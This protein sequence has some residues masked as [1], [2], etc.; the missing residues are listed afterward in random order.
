MNFLEAFGELDKLNEEVLTEKQWVAINPKG[1]NT[2]YR[3]L[4][5]G[6]QD[7]GIGPIQKADIRDM[8]GNHNGTYKQSLNKKVLAALKSELENVS[9]TTGNNDYTDLDNC[10]IVPEKAIPGDKEVQTLTL[11]DRSLRQQA[12]KDLKRDLKNN[13][14][15]EQDLENKLQG[16][17]Y[18]IHHEDGNEDNN[19]LSN[20]ILVPY[21]QNNKDDLNVANGVHNLL[22]VIAKK[23]AKTFSINYNT[24]IYYIDSQGKIQVGTFEIVVNPKNNNV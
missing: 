13:A 8:L 24:D 1:S 2:Y 18:L 3:F 23:N 14:A 5:V 4:T 7:K 12:H 17:K 21:F 22:H 16:R 20:L 15:L 11:A 10:Q 9:K 19:D 6:D